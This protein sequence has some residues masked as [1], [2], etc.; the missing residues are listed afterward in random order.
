MHGAHREAAA[1]AG[2]ERLGEGRARPQLQLLHRAWHA[3][4]QA[5]PRTQGCRVRPDAGNQ[6]RGRCQ[7]VAP[8]LAGGDPHPEACDNPDIHEAARRTEDE[9]A[10][11][12][13][14]V[15][16]LLTTRSCTTTPVEVAL[17]THGGPTDRAALGNA[18][19]DNCARSRHGRE[20]AGAP[21]DRVWHSPLSERVCTS[22]CRDGIGVSSGAAGGRSA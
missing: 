19:P 5:H 20:Q 22:R 18:P 16:D 15:R 13:A 1:D 4:P 11:F 3:A 6:P 17:A 12:D 10:H 21:S 7:P 2:Q 14:V 8:R 9:D